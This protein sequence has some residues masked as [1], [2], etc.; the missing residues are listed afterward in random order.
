MIS[1]SA[2]RKI[3]SGSIALPASKSE[4][5]RALIIQALNPG[6]I[7]LDNLSSARDTQT[8]IKLLG[9][10]GHVLDVIDAGTTM[11]FLTGYFAAVGRDQILTGTPRMC[12]RPIGILVN[13]LRELG[14]EINYWSQEGFPPL[15]I[16]SKGSKMEGGEIRMAGNVSSQFITSILLIAPVVKGG[17]RLELTGEI[18]SRP[19]IEMTISLMKKFGVEPQ[20]EGQTLVVPEKHYSGGNYTIESDWS[21]ASYWYSMVALADGADI[22]L[23]GLREHSFQGDQQV[24][25]IMEYFGVASE[26]Q[27]GGVKLSKISPKNTESLLE[28]DFTETPDLAQTI[29]VVSAATGIPIRMTGLHTLRIKETDR[30]DALVNELAKFGVNMEV[31]GNICTVRGQAGSA[32]KSIKTYDDHRMAMAFAPM[33]LRQSELLMKNPGVVK[34]SYPEY[35]D[36]LSQ[37]GITHSEW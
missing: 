11:R 31:E 36:H 1:L 12:K 35:W 20:W 22:F 4:S 15:H 17:V 34:K 3:L 23:Q 13:A 32:E 18:T 30:I 10:E 24:A 27:E 6:E 21:A 33:A 37:V 14:A 19:Y 5:N 16:V 2:T 26:Y 25:R 7:N 28:W 29:A 9:S 8:M